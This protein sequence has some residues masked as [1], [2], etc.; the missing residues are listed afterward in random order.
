MLQVISGEEK[1]RA[2]WRLVEKRYALYFMEYLFRYSKKIKGAELDIISELSGPYIPLLIRIARRGDAEQRARAINTLSHLNLKESIG[3]VAEALKD[4]SPIVSMVAA[5][6]IAQKQYTQYA[7]SIVDNLHRYR[8]WSSNM[9]ASILANMGAKALP[10]Y[11]KALA[12][13]RRPLPVRSIVAKA[14]DYMK[15]VASADIAEKVIRD[16]HNAELLIDCLRLIAD[17]GVPTHAETVRQM[18]E[19]DHDIVKARAIAALA[20]VG[21]EGDI[22]RIAVYLDSPS[23]WLE[24]ET[25]RALV[26]LGGQEAL[27]KHIPAG[28]VAREVADFVLKEGRS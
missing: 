18:L 3:T 26:K 2:L 15:D 6:V 27:E 10:V 20:T 28:S 12:D 4:K 7:P 21:D 19:Y 22:D 13:E 5:R 1:P 8:P 25:A 9:L 17:L 16:T 14:L 24:I 11:R 23:P